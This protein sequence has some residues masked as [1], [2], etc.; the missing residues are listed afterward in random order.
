[1]SS[2]TRDNGCCKLE[3]KRSWPEGGRGSGL[4]LLEEVCISQHLAESNPRQQIPSLDQLKDCHG[5][6]LKNRVTF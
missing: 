5:H 3:L 4:F 1:M 6:F 2:R